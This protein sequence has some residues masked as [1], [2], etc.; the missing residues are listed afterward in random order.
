VTKS[1]SVKSAPPHLE[2]NNRAGSGQVALWDE[3]SAFMKVLRT[4][5]S[6]MAALKWLPLGMGAVGT[7]LLWRLNGMLLLTLMCAGATGGVIYALLQDRKHPFREKLLKWVQKGQTPLGISVGVG[8]L[9]LVLS[10]SAIAVWQDLDSPWLALM[11]LT[12]EVGL[13]LVLGLVLWSVVFRP[14]Q[15]PSVSFDR[16]V[17]GLLHRDGLRRLMAVRQLAD[18]KRQG[19]LTQQQQS[20]TV[21]YL[22]LLSRRESDLIVVQGIQ[23]TL[24]LLDSYPQLGERSSASDRVLHQPLSTQM[25]EKAIT[26]ALVESV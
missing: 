16:C 3:A 21:E 9:T 25:R 20:M 14:Q 26:D 13:L 19:Q 18:L 2:R 10:Y 17:A 1:F 6:E 12:Q 4:D 7:L 15:N 5:W 8:V 11:L 23:E 22:H 24:Q